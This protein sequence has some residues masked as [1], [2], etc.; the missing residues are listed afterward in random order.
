M[1]IRVPGRFIAALAILA[2]SLCLLPMSSKI[3]VARPI[4]WEDVGP[5]TPD[6]KG[7]NDGVV[8]KSRTAPGV[9]T[10]YAGGSI[11]AVTTPKS[12]RYDISRL[13]IF[14]AVTKLDYWSFWLR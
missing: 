7:D 6:P 13:R 4:G 8:L 14:F 10:T 11:G 1:R 9:T 2:A 3:A 5:P 12:A